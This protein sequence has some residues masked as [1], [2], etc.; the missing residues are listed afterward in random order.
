MI[1]DEFAALTAQKSE[2]RA[3]FE[4]MESWK[5]IGAQL[6]APGQ[7]AWEGDTTRLQAFY[8]ALD[9][10]TDLLRT[11]D[12]TSTSSEYVSW[13]KQAQ[14][15]LLTAPEFDTNYQMYYRYD[16][17]S[18][19]Y[20]WAVEANSDTWMSQ[21]EADASPSVTVDVAPPAASDYSEPEFDDGYGMF[22]RFSHEQQVYEWAYDKGAAEW[23]SQAQA[24]ALLGGT[25]EHGT[26]EHGT[27]PSGGEYT[28]PEFDDRY[29]MFYRFNRATEVYEWAHDK[30]AAEW[31]SQAQADATRVPSARPEP[32]SVREP[33]APVSVTE[34]AA[35][36]LTEWM[37][38][39]RADL[40]SDVISTVRDAGLD[41]ADITDEQLMALVDE[42]V[43]EDLS[44]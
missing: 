10:H 7:E 34:P 6:G 42:L 36:D 28:D 21:A 22:Y 1:F 32:V 27:A 30:D 19:V 31:M 44:S 35:E 5:K 26:A 3:G 29:G 9:T 33:A 41:P 16:V 15:A 14:A 23:M 2:F 12:L 39:G 11:F 37:A 8:T 43:R 24:D 18:G 38:A 20:Q 13:I 17:I 40:L 4:A 25:A